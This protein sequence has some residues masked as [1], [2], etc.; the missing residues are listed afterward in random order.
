[1]DNLN[2]AI[3]IDRDGTLIKN[4]GYVCFFSSAQLFEY[5]T[6]AVRKINA[7][8]YKAVI[9]TNQS[10]IARGICTREQVENFHGELIDFFQKNDAEISKIYYCP[11]HEEGVIEPFIKTSILRK[12]QPGMILKAAKDLNIDLKFSYMI[13][14]NSSDIIAGKNSGCRTALVLTGYGKTALTELEQKNIH[15]DI[16]ADNLLNAVNLIF[17]KQGI[18][19]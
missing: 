11:Y 10:S 1:M 16:V 6:R 19:P 12:P 8:G 14:D 7:E 2:R 13:G 4:M 17:N 15:P 5:S 9:I 18:N 3:F